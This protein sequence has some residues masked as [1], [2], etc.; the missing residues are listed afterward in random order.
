MDMG[1]LLADPLALRGVTQH[2]SDSN[3]PD[4]RTARQDRE[5]ALPDDWDAIDDDY[6][7]HFHLERSADNRSPGWDLVPFRHSTPLPSVTLPP[8]LLGLPP[9]R[10]APSP[11]LVPPPA[12][13]PPTLLVREG[14][15]SRPSSPWSP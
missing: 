11:V 9:A 13:S 10:T 4:W 14:S 2:W 7:T 15:A 6:P 8:D 1:Y 12:A 5:I 3:F